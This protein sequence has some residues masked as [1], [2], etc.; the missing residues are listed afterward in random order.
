M[1]VE[2][3]GQKDHGL[4]VEVVDPDTVVSDTY[5]NESDARRA[6]ARQR[7]STVYW[8]IAAA[9]LIL[10]GEQ[11]V[12]STVLFTPVLARVAEEFHTSQVVWMLT[13][14][15]LAAAVLTPLLTKLGDVYG[16]RRILLPVLAGLAYT[17]VSATMNFLVALHWSASPQATDYGFGLSSLQI[18]WWSSPAGVLSA[19][20]GLIVGVT[21]RSIG[22]RNHMIIA[23]FLWVVPA[24]VLGL[25]LHTSPVLI[26]SVYALFGFANMYTAAALCLLLLAAPGDQRGVVLGMQG[27]IAGIAAAAIQQIAFVILSKSVVS[28]AGG[29]PIYSSGG[30][31]TAYVVTGLIG[32]IGIVASVFTP[33]GRRVRR[34]A[35]STVLVPQMEVTQ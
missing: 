22:Y 9:A 17:G 15:T 10:L 21:A 1:P 20:A 23:G 19:V 3:P 14:F 2:E 32:V 4:G 12:L 13:T 29:V 33:Q 16:K 7:S 5:V 8:V 30:F 6:E 25:N 31:T 34:D 18:G 26:I 35:A 11:T 24:I 27:A 28:V